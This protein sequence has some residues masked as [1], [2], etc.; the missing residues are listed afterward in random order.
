[1]PGQLGTPENITD[2]RTHKPTTALS[3]LSKDAALA[4]G[5]AS[6]HFTR[7][8]PVCTLTDHGKAYVDGMENKRTTRRGV[9]KKKNAEKSLVCHTSGAYSS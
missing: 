2:S 4:V 9:T 6:L 8:R 3:L 5:V 1:M 7:K